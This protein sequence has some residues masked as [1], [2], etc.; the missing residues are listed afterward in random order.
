[1]ANK[2]GRPTVMTNEVV[3]KLEYGFMKGLTDEQ[4]CLYVGISKQALYDYCHS[5]PEFTDRKELL[6]QQP[7]VQA[8]LNVSEEIENGNA[9]ISKWYLERRAKDEFS[10]KQEIS[11]DIDSE[12]TISIELSDDE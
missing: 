3:S 7:T 11:A 12:V 2:V 4:C 9:D 5:H 1:M 10:T 6:K 8:K